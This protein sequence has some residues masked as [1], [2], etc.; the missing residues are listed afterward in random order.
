MFAF[1]NFL[2][3]PTAQGSWGVCLCHT[4]P[5]TIV[6]FCPPC[7]EIVAGG[8]QT[9]QHTQSAWRGGKDILK[10]LFFFLASVTVTRY[11]MSHC[12]LGSETDQ[13]SASSHA[14]LLIQRTTAF[15]GISFLLWLLSQASLLRGFLLTSWRPFKKTHPL[16]PF[17][18]STPIPAAA[19]HS[20]WVLGFVNWK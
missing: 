11:R 20:A 10:M 17:F 12:P 15:S 6:F 18:T 8:L 1:G 13:V 2:P 14:R 4:P 19:P 9:T 5:T 16:C 3:T 7:L